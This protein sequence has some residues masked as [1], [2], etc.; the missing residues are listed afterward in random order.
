MGFSESCTLQS[1]I[2]LLLIRAEGNPVAE[3]SLASSCKDDH[4]L[5]EIY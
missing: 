1:F 3:M 4:G 5:L 2:A